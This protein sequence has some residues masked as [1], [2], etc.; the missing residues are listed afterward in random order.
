[1]FGLILLLAGNNNGVR[2]LGLLYLIVGPLFVRVYCE[3][4]I[5]IFKMHESLVAIQHNTAPNAGTL[6][7]GQA[8]ALS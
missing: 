1:V 2:V 6:A 3:I 4:L 8:D 5:V 7:H